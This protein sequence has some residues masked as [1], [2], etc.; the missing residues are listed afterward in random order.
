M[1]DNNP[2]LETASSSTISGSQRQYGF[3]NMALVECDASI[4]RVM[5]DA[6]LLAVDV[7]DKP[8]RCYLHEVLSIYNL[9]PLQRNE[10]YLRAMETTPPTL[11]DTHVL[12]LT[13]EP[14]L[15]ASRTVETLREA[16]IGFALYH[17]G[18]T[19][20]HVSQCGVRA[21]FRNQQYG[22]NIIKRLVALAFSVQQQRITHI[23]VDVRCSP[24]ALR[25][26]RRQQFRLYDVILWKRVCEALDRLKPGEASESEATRELLVQTL[27]EAGATLNDDASLQLL[28][29]PPICHVCL[30]A[31]EQKTLQRCGAC[32]KVNYCSRACQ[33]AHWGRHKAHCHK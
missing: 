24:G 10:I 8:A 31:L 16:I 7:D 25:F 18:T 17:N 15:G 32:H 11:I 33:T 20:F 12:I 21:A 14:E 27:R 5:G 3:I 13:L 19:H 22:A 2:T 9:P 28:F 6:L 29:V 30:K 1:A 4:L 26:F 23:T